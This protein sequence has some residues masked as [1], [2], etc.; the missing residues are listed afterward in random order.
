MGA[1]CD[2]EVPE[3]TASWNCPELGGVFLRENL[4]ISSDSELAACGRFEISPICLLWRWVGIPR[5]E[6][7]G[8]LLTVLL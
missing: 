3:R 2:Q 7:M 4:R 8:S 6:E 1:K 5:R